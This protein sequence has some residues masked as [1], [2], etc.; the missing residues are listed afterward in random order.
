V[1]LQG[2]EARTANR[3]RYLLK[4]E[5]EQI[6]FPPNVIGKVVTRTSQAEKNKTGETE[7]RSDAPFRCEHHKATASGGGTFTCSMP[8]L[9]LRA[10]RWIKVFSILIQFSIM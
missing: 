1:V 10:P 8:P 5:N 3:T 6:Y 4:V 2:S 9:F 7:A